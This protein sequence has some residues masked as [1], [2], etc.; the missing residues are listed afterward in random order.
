VAGIP[1]L[2]GCA[3]RRVCSGRLVRQGIP[4]PGQLELLPRE[5]IKEKPKPAEAGR[6]RHGQKSLSN[7][8]IRPSRHLLSC[9]PARMKPAS[10]CR[11]SSRW[12][13][14]SNRASQSLRE[15]KS[16]L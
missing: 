9:Y 3:Q 5:K 4:I 8:V 11:G 7:H 14:I 2:G 1:H 12:M 10:I 16:I 13:A 15:K 6:L